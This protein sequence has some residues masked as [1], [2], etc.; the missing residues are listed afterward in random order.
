[1]LQLFLLI[2]LVPCL[3]LRQV[4]DLSLQAVRHIIACEIL[5]SALSS[6]HALCISFGLISFVS[7]PRRPPIPQD[8]VVTHWRFLCLE[9]AQ[10]QHAWN[11]TLIDILAS[12]MWAACRSTCWLAAFTRLVDASHGAEGLWIIGPCVDAQANGH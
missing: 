6:S 10:A 2:V 4:P 5:E 7:R 11:Y 1:M 3:F 12:V 9:H 8:G